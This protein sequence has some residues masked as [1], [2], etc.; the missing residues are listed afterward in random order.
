M[1]RVSRSL[2]SRFR[3]H[4]Q[5]KFSLRFTRP[6][7]VAQTYTSTTGMTGQKHMY[8]PARR[9]VMNMSVKSPNSAMVLPVFTSDSVSAA[10]VISPAVTAETA[11]QAI[12]SGVKIPLASVLTETALLRNTFA[13][14]QRMLS[15]LTK[16]SM[17]MSYPSSMHSA[18]QPTRL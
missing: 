3:S 6:Q 14:P 18:M 13:S 16:V 1:L 10:K 2:R 15:S 9:S 5:E 7:F 4:R 11:I 8:I 17:R 12:F